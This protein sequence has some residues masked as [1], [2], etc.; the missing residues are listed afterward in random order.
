MFRLVMCCLILVPMGFI[1]WS[2]Q[3]TVSADDDALAAVAQQRAALAAAMAKTQ[4]KLT[5]HEQEAAALTAAAARPAPRKPAAAA[6]P[7]AGAPAGPP[8]NL[9]VV[10]ES[11]PKL[12]DLYLKNF[13]A[14]LRNRFGW[15]YQK[16]G[17]T[18]DQIDKLEDLDT[19]HEQENVDLRAAAAAQG[20]PMS[21]PG[22][23]AMHQQTNQ[24]FQAAVV[25]A[26]G[27]PASQQIAQYASSAP[28]DGV[29]ALINDLASDIALS[30]TPMTYA[31]I[32]Q[33]GP[34]LM[35]NHTA[36]GAGLA[37]FDWDKVTA[38]AAGVLSPAQLQALQTRAS[39]SQITG[40]VRQ[41]YTQPPTP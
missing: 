21:D 34:I 27:A 32:G 40:L 25:A 39:L 5:A 23:V 9:Y 30:P 19:S 6:N 10:L 18:A 2:S 29:Q 3:Q 16:V 14:N 35:A 17:L 12:L 41:Y 28:S 11:D 7:S 13:K 22:I 20:L 4:A 36:N 26:I 37:S 15:V 24:Q 31:E 8:R 38:Q 1:I 33:L